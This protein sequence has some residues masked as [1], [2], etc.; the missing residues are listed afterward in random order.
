[1]AAKNPVD[2]E[3]SSIGET[4]SKSSGEIKDVNEKTKKQMRC[5]R[6]HEN[7]NP[8]LA[9]GGANRPN[10]VY[11]RNK[12]NRNHV[13]GEMT[14]KC[15]GHNNGGDRP[16]SGKHRN[17]GQHGINSQGPSQ[18]Q[19]RR[20]E[21]RGHGRRDMFEPYWP[22]DKLSDGLK[23]GE[24]IQGVIRVNPKNFED[25]YVPLPDGSADIYIPGMRR[26]NR[27]LNGDVVAVQLLDRNEWRVYMN[28][29]ENFERSQAGAVSVVA[30]NDADSDDSG[31]DVIIEEEEVVDSVG[32]PTAAPDDDRTHGQTSVSATVECVTDT[33]SGHVK[34]CDIQDNKPASA[35]VTNVAS[36]A[37]TP[38]TDKKVNY[39]SV[40]DILQDGSPVMKKLFSGESKSARQ[41]IAQDKFLQKTGKVVAVIERIHSRACGGYIKPMRDKNPNWALFSPTDSRLPR[42]QIP[43]VECPQDF[44]TRPNDHAN[45]LFIA[46]ISDWKE[47]SAYANGHLSRSLGEAGQIEPETE[48]LLIEND[49]DYSEFSDK[50]LACLP[51][52]TPWVIPQEEY[53]TRR[54][55]RQKC[56]FTIDPST[57]RDLDDAVSC[58]NMGDGT[59]EVGVHIADVSFFLH[60]DT[61]LDSTAAKRA[62]SVY[63]VQKVIPMLPRLLCEKLCSLNPDEDRL[64][65]SVVW[66]MNKQGEVLDEWFGRTVIRSCVKL[67]YEHAQGFIEEPDK[68]WMAEELPPI[69]TGFTVTDITSRVLHLQEMAKC[70]RKARFDGGALRLDQVKI[71]YT[72]DKDTGLPNGYFVYQQRDSN[73]LIEEF[74]LLANMAVAHRIY[75]FCPEKALLRRHPA[76]QEKALDNLMQLAQELG[77]PLD[78]RDSGSLHASLLKYCG[79]DEYSVARMQVLVAMCSKPMQNARYFCT[80]LIDDEEVYRHYALNVP[81]YTH[82]TSPIRRYPDIMVHRLLAASLDYCDIPKASK[83]EIQIEAENC[84]ERKVAAKRV[85]DLSSELFFAV[86]VKEAGPFE[87]KAMVMGV[88]D[89]SFDIFILKFGV[90]KRVYC[91]KL[92]LKSFEFCKDHKQPVL[93]LVWPSDDHHPSEETQHI[94]VFTI[95]NAQLATDVGPLKWKALISRL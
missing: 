75:K 32:L 73:K 66:K 1:M 11:D 27:A 61:P 26:R 91:E 86:F 36:K 76:P 70:L 85:S 81:L 29:L 35:K 17:R 42:L 95:V 41:S 83:K 33:L 14:E 88:L 90:Q 10:M 82:F 62:N 50:V 74:M 84:N 16:R 72:L 94:A 34:S 20:N 2:T 49:V 67:S 93:T 69:S 4:A 58:E 87:E 89:K 18:T 28:D 25:S 5:G 79:E 52:E 23:R 19:D 68:E 64:T 78:C 43:V 40:K 37:H 63:L 53:Q 22:R 9:S 55:F 80:G 57:A 65:F 8:M 51:S 44:L 47:N 31:P 13:G 92:N 54:D 21:N 7:N 71:Q 38:K 12:N 15:V 6:A 30:H 39:T 77:V 48:A 56:V 60:E 45:T 3:V 46:R 59:Y 24:L